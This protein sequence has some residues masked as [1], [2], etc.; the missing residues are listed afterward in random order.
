MR[1]LNQPQQKKRR[2]HLS[3][4]LQS[5]FLTGSLIAAPWVFAASPESSHEG[6]ATPVAMPGWT[7]N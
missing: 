2:K 1:S 3:L 5:V 7:Q 6:H 4:M